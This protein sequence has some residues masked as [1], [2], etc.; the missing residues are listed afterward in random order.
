RWTSKIAANFRA[1]DGHTQLMS[2]L[3]HAA[4]TE[5]S[6]LLFVHAGLDPQ[7]PLSEQADSFWWGGAGFESIDAPYPDFRRVVR[8]YCRRHGGFKEPPFP[9]PLD[10]GCGFGGPLVAGCFNPHGDFEGTLTA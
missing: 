5:D 8:G 6:S 1:H 2:V 4:V 10:C 7:R 9:I 3:F